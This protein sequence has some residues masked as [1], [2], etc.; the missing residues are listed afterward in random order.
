MSGWP[1]MTMT[2]A[3]GNLGHGPADGR[4]VTLRV[5]DFYRPHRTGPQAGRI[6]ENWMLLD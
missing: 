4:A 3:A 5:M 6:A 2:W 1:S